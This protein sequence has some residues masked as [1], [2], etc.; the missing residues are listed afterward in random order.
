M[1]YL[2]AGTSVPGPSSWHHSL[3]C[4]TRDLSLGSLAT[5]HYSASG[6]IVLTCRAP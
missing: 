1:P 6:I 3:G 2:A 4:R 5:L